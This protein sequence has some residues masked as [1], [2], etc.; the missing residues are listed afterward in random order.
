MTRPPINAEDALTYYR[1]IL[2]NEPTELRLIHPKTG[3]TRRS[4]GYP[5]NE[6]QLG[7]LAEYNAEGFGVY[8]AVNEL[9]AS[10]EQRCKRHQAARDQDVTA[11]RAVFIDFDTGTRE[12]NEAKLAASPLTPSMTICSGLESKLHAYW[13]MADLPVEDFRRTQKAL[14]D[15]FGSDQKIVNEARVMR[16]P[17]FVNTKPEYGPAHPLARILT[18][19]GHVYTRAELFAAFNIPSEPPAP[20][21]RAAATPRPPGD[22]R[23]RRYALAALDAE[24]QAVRAATE[25]NRNDQLN[26]SAFNLGQLIAGG[27]LDRAVVENILSDAAAAAGLAGHEIDGTIRSGIEAGILEPRSAP[28]RPQRER[29]RTKQTDA[30]A[31]SEP[32]AT[33]GARPGVQVNNRWLMDISNETVRHLTARNDP[34]SLFERSGEVV[35]V[36]G[37]GHAEV[38][39]NPAFKGHL[40]RNIRFYKLEA[41]KGGDGEVIEAPARPPSDLG[42]DILS[43][44]VKPFPSLTGF[45]QTPVFLPGGRLLDQEGYDSGTG[46]LLQLGKLQGI[47]TDL[48]TEEALKVLDDVYGD[49]PYADSDAGRAHT[50]AATLQ[51]FVR[52]MID[53]PT[54]MALVDA[55]TRGTGKGLLVEVIAIITTGQHADVMHLPREGDELEKRITATVMAGYPIMLLD[56]VTRLDQPALM[57]FLTSTMWRGRR[58]GKSEMV[59]LLNMTLCIA[60]GNNV[61]LVDEMV[62]R[63]YPIR[64]DAGV[65]RPE[66]RTGFKH[67]NLSIYVREN[68][69]N[70]VSA[71]LSLVQRW[72]DAGMPPGTAALGRFESWA[73]I[74]G[75]ILAHAGVAGFL[76]GRER[77]HDQA[78]RETTDWAA[79]TAAW[80][81]QHEQLAVTAKDVLGVMRDHGLLLDHWAGRTDLS[82]QQRVGRALGKY[83]DRVFG[84]HQI[85]YAGPDSITRNASYRLEPSQPP[86]KLERS[87]TNTRNTRNTQEDPA[88]SVTDVNTAP[89]VSPRVSSET[90]TNTRETP[91]PGKSVLDGVTSASAGV[92]GVSGVING[93]PQN[94]HREETPSLLRHRAASLTERYSKLPVETLRIK[95]Q[96]AHERATTAP[97][98]W[99]TTAATEP[100]AVTV[101]LELLATDQAAGDTKPPQ[102]YLTAARQAA[103][104]ITT[105]TASPARREPPPGV[106]L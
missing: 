45:A 64:L 49:F 81:N 29:S 18:S 17:G 90:P 21:G 58:L 74:L 27:T 32:M 12:E 43:L 89:G 15:H 53:G 66:E 25:G 99:K 91:G 62:R 24:A 80:W 2:R 77:L 100:L 83:R 14:A 68:R 63:V 3:A 30:P 102:A 42:P 60:T 46:L 98:W 65:D 79:L 51:P 36:A 105:P 40:E 61:E 75:G 104:T 85:K 7:M 56:N 52:P 5:E 76:E 88:N 94:H 72:V 95:Y 96:V 92:S 37:R 35:R 84:H 70:L 1:L 8:A 106:P 55:P 22:D 69:S 73:A 50:L 16:V 38:L 67:G 13:I 41:A 44:E 97:T 20:P 87:E 19:P 28:E 10:V 6:K 71:C 48:S 11:V 47:R 31:V 33:E 103:A 9:D 54:P 57:A 86:I 93:P 59:T 39:S 34:P 4:W 78:D 23:A 101:A 82:A 26:R